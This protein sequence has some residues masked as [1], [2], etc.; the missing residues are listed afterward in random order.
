MLLMLFIIN[1]TIATYAKVR[2]REQYGFKVRLD[3]I[4]YCYID[5]IKSS[6]SK[7]KDQVHLREL[8]VSMA[9]YHA[10]SINNKNTGLNNGRFEVNRL[11]P[12]QCVEFKCFYE[13]LLF[14]CTLIGMGH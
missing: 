14:L 11:Q 9:T 7:N 12:F 10:T 1:A 6:V 5:K 13:F 4:T 2:A 8:S 3:C